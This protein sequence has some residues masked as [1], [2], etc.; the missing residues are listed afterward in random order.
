M[1][2][3]VIFDQ[4]EDRSNPNLRSLG[5]VNSF[6]RAMKIALETQSNDTKI[7]KHKNNISYLVVS[8]R[9]IR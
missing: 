9:T 8:F 3:E 1:Q 7:M 2:Y 4:S 6:E 5:K